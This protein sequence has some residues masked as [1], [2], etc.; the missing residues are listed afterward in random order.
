MSSFLPVSVFMRDFADKSF[1][2]PAPVAAPSFNVR[3]E[4]QDSVG[5]MLYPAHPHPLQANLCYRLCAG[6]GY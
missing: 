4:I 6:K 1:L 5:P 2:R 3:I